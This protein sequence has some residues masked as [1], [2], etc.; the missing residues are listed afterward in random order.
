MAKVCLKLS[1]T[2]MKLLNPARVLEELSHK[3][4]DLTPFPLSILEN[5]LLDPL[6][7]PGLA[8]PDYNMKHCELCMNFMLCHILCAHSSQLSGVFK[9]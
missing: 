6:R 4:D 2:E 7:W 8:I 5:H 9:K 3:N 1:S